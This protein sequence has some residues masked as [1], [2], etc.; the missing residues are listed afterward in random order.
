MDHKPLPSGRPLGTMS[1]DLRLLRSDPSLEL[2]EYRDQQ[3]GGNNDEQEKLPKES[4]TLYV[5]NLSFYTTEEQIYELFSRCGD[6]KNM[7]MGLDKIKK[8]ACGFCFVE[9][10]NRFEAENAMWCLNGTRLDDRIIHTDWDLGFR[11]GRQYGRPRRGGQVR[12]E[13]HEDFNAGRGGFREAC[14]RREIH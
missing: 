11:Q 6:V 3:F 7:F 12:D 5:G 2:S 4:F 13:F 9:Y 1:N 14:D 8:M 10:H